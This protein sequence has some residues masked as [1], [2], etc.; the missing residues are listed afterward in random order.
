MNFGMNHAPVAGSIAHRVDLQSITM[1]QLPL[2]VS[3]YLNI[4]IHILSFLV[5][6]KTDKNSGF[7]HVDQLGA[8]SIARRMVKLLPVLCQ[9]LET[10]NSFF[11][12]CNDDDDDDNSNNCNNN[13]SNNNNNNN[14]NIV[15]VGRGGGYVSI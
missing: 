4:Y 2:P 15:V 1:L 11:Q 6:S 12:V 13:N 14:S 3:S 7:S 5:Q 8:D 10:A 9:H